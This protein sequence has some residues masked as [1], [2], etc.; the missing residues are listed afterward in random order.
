MAE[1]SRS[2]HSGTRKARARNDN[3]EARRANHSDAQSVR[4]RGCDV[5]RSE[6][7]SRKI[8]ARKSQFRKALQADQCVQDLPQ[9]YSAFVF[10]EIEDYYARSAPT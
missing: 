3:G 5:D 8:S 10:S 6:K 2:R 1:L 4:F 7:T 9:K